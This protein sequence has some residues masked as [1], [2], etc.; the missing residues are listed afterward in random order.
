MN[1][2][3]KKP[4]RIGILI[5]HPR[6][7]KKKDELVYC[8]SNKRPWLKQLNQ[9]DELKKIKSKITINNDKGKK[10]CP[11][12]VSVGIYIRW[13]YDIEVDL[14]SP[15]EITC[16]RLKRN[17]VNFLLIYDLLEAFHSKSKN[18][19]SFKQLEKILR[20]AKNVYPPYKD[21]ALI[22]NK[23]S[24]INYLSKKKMNVIP[25]IQVERSEYH[26]W[27]SNIN[28]Y[29]DQL[30][31]K[32]NRK[33]WKQFIAKPLFGQESI[34]FKRFSADFKKAKTE[35]KQYLKKMLN[36]KINYPGIILQKYIEGFDKNKPEIRLY[37]FDGKYKYSVVT[38]GSRVSIPSTE[39]GTMKVPPMEGLKRM[40]KTIVKT[41]PEIKMKGH[42]LPRVLTRVDIAC[43]KNF[44]K[45]W[46][47][48][49]VE[50]VPSLYIE[51][52][53]EIPEIGLGDSMV[54]IARKLYGKKK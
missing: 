28:K 23:Y 18:D 3:K 21:Q 13:K 48:N 35:L 11:G 34:G 50:F 16:D 17:T 41:L 27:K 20:S 22:N 24:Y 37:Y 52:V 14:I 1:K 9:I 45:P 10:C 25:S 47:V 38:T 12:D 31:S 4:L 19:K 49:E 2:S 29:I 40:G 26:K 46:I 42:K 33:G 36:G 51:D 30:I 43:E 32:I 44:K 5:T 39:N 54:R 15:N 53:N 6:S 8:N 7:E